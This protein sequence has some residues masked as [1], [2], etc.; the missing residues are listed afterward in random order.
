MSVTIDSLLES[1]VQTL[2]VFAF[3]M[4]DQV[5]HVEGHNYPIGVE[6]ELTGSIQGK[7]QAWTD[8]NLL[9]GVCNTILG[10]VPPE[11][12]FE[13]AISC[14][15][16]VVNIIAG[17]FITQRYGVHATIDLGIPSEIK[18]FNLMGENVC[19]SDMETDGRIIIQAMVNDV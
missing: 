10:E 18:S 4:L 17:N 16:E 6:I 14:L 5:E 19:L 8:R 2:E 1:T 13:P 11:D 9:E 7:I 12:D 15:K 3:M